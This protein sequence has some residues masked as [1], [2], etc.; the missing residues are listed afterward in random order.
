ML[1][2]MFRVVNGYPINRHGKLCNPHPVDLIDRHSLYHRK[3]AR[4]SSLRKSWPLPLRYSAKVIAVPAHAILQREEAPGLALED[5]GFR[6][7]VNSLWRYAKKACE[8]CSGDRRKRH[9]ASVA[10]FLVM[11][12]RFHHL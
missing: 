12:I 10:F 1:W 7:V 4:S 6:Q 5:A 8:S 9:V 3:A 11:V 2:I